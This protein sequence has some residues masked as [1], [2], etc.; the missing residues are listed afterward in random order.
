MPTKA[1]EPDK[2]TKHI[3]A[4]T[5]ACHVSSDTSSH[6]G[7]ASTPNFTPAETPPQLQ[8]GADHLDINALTAATEMEDNN[9]EGSQ[10]KE[11]IQPPV[12]EGSHTQAEKKAQ[13]GGEAK[14][15]KTV[16]KKHPKGHKKPVKKR[17]KPVKDESSSSEDSSSSDDSSSSSES[18]ESTESESSTE[19]DEDAKKKRRNKARKAKK[20]KEKKKAKSR[21][22]KES[23]EEEPESESSEESSSEEEEKR[24]KSR[25]K[26]GRRS[27]KYRRNA[28]SSDSEE[29]EEMED[30]RAARARAQLN[31]L[32]LSGGGR[33]GR[34]RW[35]G[36]GGRATLDDR[37][38]KKPRSGKTKG[39]KKKRFV[40]CNLKLI[41]VG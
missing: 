34:G 28:E 5:P 9:A 6:R 17:S 4:R 3:L 7:G 41:V 1:S 12:A 25:S 21:K 31:A 29:E 10:A 15:K 19:E 2:P 35:I 23:S 11:D 13:E 30:D 40:Q 37:L 39:K 18:E 14:V 22:R 27:K 20:L 32:A 26:K 33:R 24:K 8:N 38:L 16:C 36:R